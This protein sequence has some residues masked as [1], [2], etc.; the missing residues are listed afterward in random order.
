MKIFPCDEIA[1]DA[2]GG[3]IAVM[4]A[5]HDEDKIRDGEVALWPTIDPDKDKDTDGNPGLHILEMVQFAKSDWVTEA[6]HG[7][8]KDFEDK[9]LLFPYFD[10][11]TIGLAISEDKLRNRIYDTL[12]DCVMEIEELK[13]KSPDKINKIAIETSADLINQLIGANVNNSSITAIVSDI[14]SKNK[15]L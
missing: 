10:A 7:M 11:A 3:G 9:V 13:K 15:T 2:Q 8:R 5:L 1:M 14:S 4:E 6:N 12:E